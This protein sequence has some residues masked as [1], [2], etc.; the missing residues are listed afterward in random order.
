MGSA[1]EFDRLSVLDH[2]HAV[3]VF[4]AEQHHGP[5][6]TGLFDRVFAAFLQRKVAADIPVDQLFDF[7]DLLVGYL[8]EMRKV[9]TQ[10]IGTYERPFCST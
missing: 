3:A 9:E 6:F 4:F 7:A 5:E 8:L 1:A 10:V 2:P